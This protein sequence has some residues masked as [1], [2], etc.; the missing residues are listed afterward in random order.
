M[1]VLASN[2]FR[3]CFSINA[4][5]WLRMKNKFF[6]KYFQL[7]MCFNGFAPKIGFIQNFHFKPFPDSRGERERERA[8]IPPSTSPI[9]KP[10][11]RSSTHEP[12]TSPA[13]HSLRATNPRTDFSLC[14]IL[15]LCDFDRPTNRSTFLCDFDFLLSLFDLWFFCCC[16][17][18]VLVVFVVVGFVWVV[19]ENN[20]FKMLPN[21]WKYFLEQFS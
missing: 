8:Q 18:G 10:T 16:C 2:H 4:N 17:G 12:S 1:F 6:G 5:V 19:M 3:K 7:I 9:Y 15:I 13:T 20:I 21:T 11:N 14:V